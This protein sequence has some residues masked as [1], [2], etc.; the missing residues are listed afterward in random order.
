M[1]YRN[2]FVRGILVAW[3]VISDFRLWVGRRNSLSFAGLSSLA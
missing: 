2:V 3:E 1:A